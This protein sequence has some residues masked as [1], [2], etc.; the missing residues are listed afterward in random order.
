[1]L[2]EEVRKNL[3]W[4]FDINKE[5]YCL[6]RDTFLAFLIDVHE[7]EPQ[8][9]LYTVKKNGSTTDE[10]EESPPRE[11]LVK[12]VEEQGGHLKKSCLYNINGEIRAWI[13]QH[14]L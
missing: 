11:M 8:L 3:N 1:M 9:V 13:E 6:D 12:A 4:D 14:L 5:L 7:G 10:L 2:I